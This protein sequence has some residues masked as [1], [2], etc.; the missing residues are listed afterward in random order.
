MAALTFATAKT[1]LY[2]LGFSDF[3]DS[4]GN[5]EL[6]V[7]RALNEAQWEVLEE[8]NH[9]LTR[10]TASGTAPVTLTRPKDVL[11]VTDRTLDTM[12]DS[13]DIRTLEN[14]YP[15]L[16]DTGTPE[17][18]YFSSE[19]AVSVYPA[20]T[21]DTIQVRYEQYP[22]EMASTDAL[23]VPQRFHGAVFHRAASKLW[24]FLSNHEE[25]A[26][27]EAEARRIID[28]FVNSMGSRERDRPG[29]IEDVV[30]RGLA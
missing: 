4:G 12:L 19:T 3:N 20:N 7:G 18:W 13:I 2:A 6:R 8:I 25:S 14:T 22:A 23:T 11:S 1:E 17:L 9:P 10:T 29:S 26:W 16:P 27:H 28:L 15:D 24:R 5:G 21:S 30:T